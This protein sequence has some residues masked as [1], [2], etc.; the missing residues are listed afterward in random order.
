MARAVEPT[1]LIVEDS[2]E[3]LEATLRALARSGRDRRI[4]HCA[5]GDEA[6]DY[7]RR[8][9]RY[10]KPDAAPR[11]AL[12]LLDLNLPGTDGRE[13]LTEIKADESLRTIPVVVLTTSADRGDVEACYR[14]GASGYVQK[15]VAHEDLVVRMRRTEEFWLDTV[16]PPTPEGVGAR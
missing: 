9:G 7:L 10:S 6:L 14:A 12:V 11:P 2:P 4:A 16:E 3:D 15:P 8:R 5:D 13:V 1:L